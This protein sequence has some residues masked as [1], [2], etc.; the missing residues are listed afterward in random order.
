MLKLEFSGLAPNCALLPGSGVAR[1]ACRVSPRQARYVFFASPKKSTE[2]KSEPDSSALRAHCDAR[3]SRGL[4]KLASL[5]QRQPLSGCTCASRLLITAG[6]PKTNSE[7][8]RHKPQG[9]AMARPC[10]LG[11]SACLDF[12]P[13]T[14]PSV[15]AEQHSRE[16][17]RGGVCLSPQG[18]FR[19]TPLA[20]SST[21]CPQR[22]KGHRQRGRLS[23]A[24]F[25]LATQRKVS[26]LS[27][28]HPDSA[29]CARPDQPTSPAGARPGLSRGL[30][31]CPQMARKSEQDP[32]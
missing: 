20:A 1:A 30:R 18:E 19:P 11:F 15:C 8:N 10:G 26:A 5:K 12:V 4:A 31:E 13:W 22:S 16:R 3:R 29:L 24:Y 6:K 28:A 2:K 17:I 9:R 32:T 21:G 25:S 27:G 14:S 7:D 23:L